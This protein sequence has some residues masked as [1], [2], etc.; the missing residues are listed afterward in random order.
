M[1]AKKYSVFLRNGIVIAVSLLALALGGPV[2]AQSRTFDIAEQNAE[3][4]V[5]AFAR[6]A[7][8]Q[9]LISATD[10]A[11]RRTQAVHGTYEVSE[12]L[13]LLING[14]GLATKEIGAH[15]Y[16]LVPAA[17]VIHTASS[18]TTPSPTPQASLPAPQ[19]NIAE[20]P[21]DEIVVTA[22]RRRE[23]AENVPISMTVA[24]GLQ[25]E[26]AGVTELQ[27]LSRISPAVQISKNGVYYQPEIRGITTTLG[28]GLENNVATY[29][30]GSYVASTRGLN[31]DLVNI[32]QIEVLKGPQGTLFGRNATGGAI[33]IQTLDPSLTEST[34][35][36]TASYG[37]YN[38]RQVQ[39]YYS[40]PLTSEVGVNL[41][42]SYHA[43]SGYIRNDSGFDDTAPLDRYSISSKLLFQPIDDFSVLAKAE[44]LKNSDGRGLAI[45]YD[46][47]GTSLAKALDP[48]TQ[49]ETG[50]Y[51]TSLNH[52][53]VDVV[54]QDN[55]SLK[56]AYQ[57]GWATLSSLS[58]YQLERSS[59][60]F[61]LDGTPALFY[62]QQ[63]RERYRTVSEDLNLTS[64]SKG[65]VQYVA[66]FYYFDLLHQIP[67]DYA[68]VFTPDFLP[69]QT[70]S[71]T[72]KAYS[73]Y[74]DVTWNAVG[75]LYFTGG[76]RY[77]H[78][79][80]HLDAYA[81]S[82]LL[83][84]GTLAYDGGV[85]FN[86]T[87]PRAV[88]RYQLDDTSNIYA[89]YT[90]G[91]KS[92]FIG[93][94]PPFNKIEPEKINAYEIGYKIAR[95]RWR[96]DTAAYY[97][98]YKDLQVSSVEIINGVENTVDTNAA[99]ARIYG[100]EAQ[101]SAQITEQFHINAG[102]AYT[103]AR[104]VSFP[105][106]PVSLPGAG[107]L[108]S[109]TCVNTAPPPATISCVQ[110]WSG[111]RMIRAP[112]WTA[113]LGLDYTV[114]TTAGK[115]VVNANESYSSAYAPDQD[116]IGLN[117]TGYRYEQ[118]GYALLSLRAAWSPPS[119]GAWTFTAFGDNVTNKRYYLSREGNAFGDYHVLA[120]PASWGVSAD[121]RF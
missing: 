76:V 114:A 90:N 77:N 16:A 110:N 101:V 80:N 35:R 9:L 93:I 2:R 118:A 72:T 99:T 120:E 23:S 94:S 8:I 30:D 48:S 104:Y 43:S 59:L 87:T 19:E 73:G 42:A 64:N 107:G 95:N 13:N 61:D 36:V 14:T 11:N 29:I 117:G 81:D 6:Q 3:E 63:T 112:D 121:F 41:A 88:V 49:L 65:P 97:Y 45:T 51:R 116:D 66:G 1:A 84:L 5:A 15:T 31:M 100:T 58:T 70:M 92:G 71:V 34:G 109:G 86:S 91:F 44:F 24:S 22:Q 57:F 47:D 62:D 106:A 50:D 18:V 75:Q 119:N 38:D 53:V 68:V 98:D 96:F 39:G 21:I 74:A 103:H 46:N 56:A 27:D 115:F 111:L 102:A 20:A 32:S 85:S 55:A 69:Q 10:A 33:M 60:A 83:G 67:Q 113:N 89:S 108:N 82:G 54:L 52:P 28:G 25:L 40:T 12:A 4:G 7:D 78:E 17:H 79:T 26:Q 105:N 37:R